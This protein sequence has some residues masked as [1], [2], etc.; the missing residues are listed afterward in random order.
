MALPAPKLHNS[1]ME[2]HEEAEDS[3]GVHRGQGTGQGGC[4]SH[5]L[6]KWASGQRGAALSTLEV[7]THSYVLLSLQDRD[8]FAFQLLRIATLKIT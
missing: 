1:T 6:G 8:A 7:P 2:R 3:K 5:C 4:A